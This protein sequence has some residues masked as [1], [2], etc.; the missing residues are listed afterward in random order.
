MGRKPTV[1]KEKIQE[2]ALRVFLK[3]GYDDT[4]MRD[5]A[6]EAD[7]SVGLAYNYF[8]TKDAVFSGAIDVFFKS[9]HVKFEQI[10]QQ[11]YRNPFQCLNTFFVEV[12]NMT[13]DFRKEF[14]GKFHWTIR[15]AIRERFLSIIETYLKRIILNVCECG[16]KPVLN[17]DL[18]TTMLTYGVCG[19]IVYSDNKF[20]DE[21][22]SELRK[23]TNLVMGLTEEK[24]GL[25]IPLYAFDKDLSQIKELFSFIGMP[26]NDMTII[27]KIRSRE[28]LVFLESNG[29]INNMVSYDLKDNVIDAF[30]IKD[31]KMKSIVEAR[32]MVSALAQ[33]PLGTVV[34]AIAKDDYTN[35]LYQDFGFKKS[36]EQKEDGKT[37]YEIL[38]PESAHDFVYAFMDKRNGK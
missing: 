21:N 4:S 24:V 12:Y 30:I 23:G 22:L 29:K 31:E 19:S 34:K 35:K 28:I 25:T 37:V 18:T 16:A 8:E 10:V 7:C 3:K 38:V 17:L 5:I 1:G 14:V 33:F 9:Y 13:T 6:K 15:Y 2:A 32:L 36:V 26:M 11:A 27:R 20:L